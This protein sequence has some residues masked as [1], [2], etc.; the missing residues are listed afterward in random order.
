MSD[1]KTITEELRD[2]L[3]LSFLLVGINPRA[4]LSTLAVSAAIGCTLN[5]VRAFI[6]D[7]ALPTSI[8]STAII[9]ERLQIP[10]HF[11]CRLLFSMAE[12]EPDNFFR[13]VQKFL[14]L[15]N[16]DSF[17]I[18]VSALNDLKN[19]LLSNP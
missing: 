6:D 11:V 8:D 18:E 9:G 15:L 4:T 3:S 14:P 12:E 13:R 16:P 7:G 10:R 19:E 5:Q 17:S 1:H 2:R